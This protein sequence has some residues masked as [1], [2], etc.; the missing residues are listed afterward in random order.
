MITNSNT[1]ARFTSSRRVITTTKEYD[2]KGRLVRETTVEETVPTPI[3][4]APVPYQ[5]YWQCG[6][7]SAVP[8][9][10]RFENLC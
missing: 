5:P 3:A 4:Q 10:R 6:S 9:A 1:L 2:E 8:P 7:T